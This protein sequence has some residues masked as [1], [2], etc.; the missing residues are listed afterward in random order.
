[1]KVTKHVRRQLRI[2]EANARPELVLRVAIATGRNG[3][4]AV[5]FGLA[6]RLAIYDIGIAACRPIVMVDFPDL[7]PRPVTANDNPDECWTRLI[8]RVEAADGCHLLVAV[9][10]SELAKAQAARCNLHTVVVASGE[11][12]QSVLGRCQAML[13]TNPPPWLRRLSGTA[14]VVTAATGDDMMP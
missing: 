5:P 6:P 8:A 11:P 3:K 13:S 4:T 2:V 1:M 12:V 7:P 14:A 10:I 9:T